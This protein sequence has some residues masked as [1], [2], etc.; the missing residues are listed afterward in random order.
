MIATVKRWVVGAAVGVLAILT[1]VFAGRRQGR[2]AQ[3][4]EDTTKAAH[5]QKQGM[6]ARRDAKQEVNKL[7]DGGASDELKR[8]WMRD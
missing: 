7:P 4:K 8:D 5:A 2:Q 6:E 1:A 3:Q